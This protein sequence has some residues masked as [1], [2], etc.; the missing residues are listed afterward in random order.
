MQ[1]LQSGQNTLLSMNRFDLTIKFES[2]RINRDDIDV[3]AYLLNTENQVR[4]D[5]DF[6]FYNQP[7]SELG[8]VKLN[9]I[10][11]GYSFSFDLG[12][13]PQN[14]LRVPVAIVLHSNNTFSDVEKLTI[15][16]DS[17]FSF[18]PNTKGM[19]EKALILGEVYS[20]RGHWKFKANGMGFD[21]GLEALATHFGVDIEEEPLEPIEVIVDPNSQVNEKSKCGVI[22]LKKT[23]EQKAPRLIDLTKPAVTSLKKNNL[24]DLKA[25]VAFVLDC[26]GSMASQFRKGYVQAVLERIAVLAVQFDDNMSLDFWAFSDN[27]KKYDDVTLDNLDNYIQMLTN[28]E[29]RGFLSRAFGGIVAELGIGNNEPPV[30][31]EVI[32]FYADSKIPAYVIFITDGG[33]YKNELIENIVRESA[34]KPLFWKFVGLGGSN[35]GVLETLDDMDG[36]IVDN[37]DFF[38]ID[39]FSSLKDGELYDQLLDEFPCWVQQAKSNDIIC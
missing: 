14:V 32:D 15:T 5:R 31:E 26:S 21:G 16:V 2:V 39:N 1:V 19:S 18:S 33:I 37:A 17:S 7:E 10:S 9:Q 28:K 20:Y 38:S 24:I 27:H 29:S 4:G 30:M 35:Y 23:I 12:R 11:G 22:D 13:L 25:R 34:S 36:R 3:S 6:I 8:S